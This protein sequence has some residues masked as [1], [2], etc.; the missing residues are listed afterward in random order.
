MKIYDKDERTV[1]LSPSLSKEAVHEQELMGSDLVRLTWYDTRRMTL[2]VGAYVVPFADK[3]DNTHYMLLEPYEPTGEKHKKYKYSPE[4]M[5]PIMMLGKL[6]FIHADGDTSSWGT[7][8]KRLDWTFYGQASTIAAYLC[9]Y[10]NE[11]LRNIAPGINDYIGDSWTAQ[12]VGD[13]PPVASLTFATTDV[14]SAAAEIADKFGCEYHFD[15]EEKVFYLGKISIIHSSQPL[16]P[17]V[18]KSGVNIGVISKSETKEE[19]ANCFQILGGKRNMTQESASGLVQST[20]RLQLDS[21]YYPDSIIDTR[22]PG[23][24]E[25]KIVRQLVFDDV[26]P[27][28]ELYVYNLRERRCWLFQEDSAGN[29]TR[30]EGSATDGVLDPEDGK[31]YKYYAKWYVRL[32]YKTDGEW[33]DY[34]LTEDK[35]IK[36]EAPTIAFQINASDNAVSSALA[37]Q[38]F[39]VV[40]YTEASP[41]KE[42]NSEE[43][44][45]GG[46]QPV[47]GDYRIEF[48]DGDIIIPTTSQQGVCPKADPTSEAQGVPSE[49]N[50]IITL[51]NVV[52]D[53]IYK[54][55]AQEELLETAEREIARLR[56][57]LNVYSFPS[58]P[59]KF[60]ENNPNLY[61]GQRII[62]DDGGD[63]GTAYGAQSYRLDT[64]IR[65]LVTRL[66]HPQMVTITVG[67]E[68]K[69]GTVSTLKDEVQS[70]IS[71]SIGTGDGIGTLTD[72]QWAQLIQNHGGRYFI[73]K[74]KDDTA[75]GEIGFLKGLWIKAKGTFGF[76]SDGNIKA[77][78]GEFSGSVRTDEVRSSNYTG[79]TI[80]DTGYLLTNGATNG[81]GHSKLTIDEIYVRM[82]AVFESLEVKKW[83]VS[84]GDEIQSCAA[85]IISRVDYFTDSGQLLGYSEVRVPWMFNRVPFLLKSFKTSIGRWLYSKSVKMRTTLSPSQLSSVSF[86][87]CYFLADD[88]DTLIENWWDDN[89]LA[90]C[91][92]MNVLRTTRNTFAP[93]KTKDSNVFWWRKVLHVSKNGV[94]ASENPDTLEGN[95]AIIDNKTYHWFDVAFNGSVEYNSSTGEMTGETDGNCFAGSDI[96]AAGDHVVQF[97]NTTQPGRMNL[98][99][100]MVNGGSGHRD[101]DPN[102]DAPCIK[103]FAGIYCFDLN[104]CF[105]GGN[106]CKMTLAPGKKYHFYGS[107]F[108]IITEYGVLPVSQTR[109]EWTEI[110]LEKDE[111]EVTPDYS[112]DILDENTGSFVSRGGYYIDSNGNRHEG[113]AQNPIPKTYVRKCY[114]YDEV[115]HNGGTWLCSIA[116]G[117]HWIADESFTYNNHIYREGTII[118]AGTYSSLDA[119]HQAMCSSHSNYTTDEPSTLSPSWTVLTNG[120]THSETRY[121]R[122]AR[123]K[124]NETL[125]KWEEDDTAGTVPPVLPWEEWLTLAQWEDAQDNPDSEYKAHKMENGD[126]MWTCTRTEF[127]GEQPSLEYQVTR[128][129]IDPDGITVNSYYLGLSDS[130]I[131]INANN[132][133]SYTWYDTFD[134]MVSHVSGG[135]SAMQGWNVWEMTVIHY[136][137]AEGRKPEEQKADVR[138]FSCNRI[139]QDGQIGEE[140]YYLLAE[141][142]VFSTVFPSY[143]YSTMG[144]RW[145]NTSNPAYDDYRL[146]DTTPNINTSMWSTR[147]PA[148]DNSTASSAAKKYLWNFEYRVDGRGTQ[149]A[150]MPRCIGNHAKGIVSIV[151]VYALSVSGQPQSGH[152]IPDDIYSANG[153]SETSISHSDPSKPKTWDDEMYNRSPSESLP[154]QWNMTIT[155]YSDNTKQY[156]YHVSSVRGTRGE[157]GAGTEYVYKLTT[158]DTAPGTPSNPSDR[159][160]DDYVPSG[161][162]DNPTGISFDYQYEWVSERHSTATTG[163]GGFTGGH[164][165]GDFSTPRLVSKWGK[166]GMDGDGVEYVFIT[167]SSNSAPYITDSSSDYGGK[168]YKDDDYLPLSSAGRCTDDPSGTTS[169][170][171][172]EWVIKRTK[173]SPNAETGKREWEEY[174]GTMS[175]WANFSENGESVGTVTKYFRATSTNSAP[176]SAETS[177]SGWTTGTTPSDWSQTKPYLWCQE[178]TV[179]TDG[180]TTRWSNVFLD[181]VWGEKGISGKD[182]WMVTANP[183]NVIIT[184][185]LDTQSSFTTATVSFSAK[186]GNTAATIR[187]ISSP[188]SST[189]K[190]SKSGDSVIVSRPESSGGNYYSEGSFSVTV[191]VTDPDTGSSVSFDIT[192]F[193]Y[194]NL[195]GTWKQSVE[196][197][198]ETI[199]ATKI[200]YTLGASG[201]TVD[202]IKADYESKRN[203][204]GT[205]ETWSTSEDTSGDTKARMNERISTAEGNISRVTEGTGDNLH[206]KQS[207]VTQYSDQITLDVRNGLTNTGID[208]T[209]HNIVAKADNFTIK[210]NSNQTTFSIDSSGN[211]NSSGSAAFNG[212]ITA[213]SGNIGKMSIG[214][215]GALSVSDGTNTTFS[216][217]A[218]GN[219]TIRGA[220]TAT[221]GSFT[222]AVTATSGSFTG[223][224]YAS[225]GTIG[226]LNIYSDGSLLVGTTSDKRFYV[227]TS[228]NVTMK[229]AITATSGTIGKMSVNPSSGVSLLVKNSS[230]QETFK[231]TDG[232]DVHIDGTNISFTATNSFK[233]AVGNSGVVMENDFMSLLI[234]DLTSA[235]PSETNSIRN[236]LGIVVSST[237]GSGANSTITLGTYDSNGNPQTGITFYKDASTS[238]LLLKSDNIS[239]DANDVISNTANTINFSAKNVNFDASKVTFGSS[240]FNDTV[241]GI[242]EDAIGD[243]MSTFTVDANRINFTANDVIGNSGSIS[244]TGHTVTFDANNVTFGDKTV[245]GRIQDKL[246]KFTV[247]AS[248]IVVEGETISI[249]S[250]KTLTFTSAGTI[251]FQAVYVKIDPN[252]LIVNANK[253]N[254]ESKDFTVSS[255]A[256]TMASTSSLDL[257]AATVNIGANQITFGGKTIALGANTLTFTTGVN[258]KIDFSSA[259]VDMKAEQINFKTGN[260][261]INN[262]TENTFSVN[263]SGNV[264]IKGAITATSGSFTGSI[265]ANEGTIGPMTITKSTGSLTFG[266]V[267]ISSAGAFSVANGSNT[268]FSIATDGKVTI[269]KKLEVATDGSLSIKNG[270]DTRFSV[271]TSG[272]VTMKGTITA[273][274]GTIG[275]LSVSSNGTLTIT[276]NRDNVTF[277]AY[278]DGRVSIL[279]DI[280]ATSGYI[281]C[282]EVDGDAL[283]INNG[284]VDTFLVDNNGNVTMN[285]VLLSGAFQTKNGLIQIYNGS[286]YGDWNSESSTIKMTYKQGEED[287][288]KVTND[289]SYTSSVLVYADSEISMFRD[290]VKIT[291]RKENSLEYGF[292]TLKGEGTESLIGSGEIQVYTTSGTLKGCGFSV[293]EF[294]I[295]DPNTNYTELGQTGTFQALNGTVTVMGGIITSI[296]S[297]SGIASDFIPSTDATYKLGDNTSGSQKRW[298]SASINTVNTLKVNVGI[299]SLEVDGIGKAKINAGNASRL[300]LSCTN[301]IYANGTIISSSDVRKKVIRNSVNVSIEDIARTP[302]FDFEWKESKG[303][304][305]LGSSAQY[306][307]TIFPNA[308]EEM[309]DGYLAMDYGSTALAA[310]VLTARTTLTHEE[311]IEKLEN[312]VQ[313][314]NNIINDLKGN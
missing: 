24:N 161:W 223:S 260:F 20:T 18:L 30:I 234:N 28:M 83:S 88:D 257:S 13:L 156:F 10:I 46:I 193:C 192:V 122:K 306:L 202:A 287:F 9:T 267:T 242:A 11:Y 64:H 51:G 284:S 201:S 266:N 297:T 34:I 208:I 40:S 1:I 286:S 300:E 310:A 226:K 289:A 136:D 145:Y 155:T 205:W 291:A 77:N 134:D 296:P 120:V 19:Y 290:L 209:N 69:K 143:S 249:S 126:F 211:L 303:K 93:V 185:N 196:N 76:D 141:S 258:G 197:G 178:K 85:N 177:T 79:D 263:S 180:T 160:V 283:T 227:D 264:T 301:G 179:L 140:E 112:D 114:W 204:V 194:A 139:G 271:D 255:C 98:W 26:Y 87:R 181:G 119:E 5:H 235:S 313:R 237:S 106:P 144:I 78:S 212:K 279:G 66:D 213:S 217:D 113:S 137:L 27:K 261:S 224:V 241:D 173:G 47:Y 129:G 104:K 23:S 299:M 221:S 71:G 162:T 103:G 148:Y 216:V 219:L 108:R 228:G 130:T 111:Y 45:D 166:N 3:G 244:F 230:N 100:K 154:Y 151:E 288:F 33:H 251:D 72:A 68:K 36:D 82:K 210:N 127:S 99:I 37:G 52:V 44:I 256:I 176:T 43:D 90:R 240:S 16:E 150:T 35:Q 164:T 259:T 92:T 233:T 81:L 22:Q 232:G 305:H 70:I 293:H 58:D 175:L 124:W 2:P 247:K 272:N 195:L 56:S 163:T 190:V 75:S 15:F 8:T 252:D 59:I 57:D 278:N 218:N 183:A 268:T 198:E 168:R 187:S 238:K 54:E 285:D 38:E 280:N 73:S 184:Q 132:Y 39:D 65:K 312:E 246:D 67:N 170:T 191:T 207:E 220:V 62:M 309:E 149:Y 138:N 214:S 254:F 95:P 86:C 80:A 42:Y 96:P 199:A 110:A 63:L 167:T 116:D 239:F 304:L 215:N 32:A 4:F 152:H 302:V 274:S 91:Q 281:G 133:N 200:I 25:P 6:P 74:L 48:I 128:W 169:S 222:G 21:A 186:K 292:I 188:T 158:D 121:A 109:G 12:I 50:N 14:L 118:D 308:V 101:Y 142:D 131:V 105:T 53:D 277:K 298:L 49:K 229:G 84:A 41:A 311:K 270:T 250:G 31:Y 231:I 125:Q 295:V 146:S 55:M 282:M 60:K 245:D 97:G 94:P 265:Y 314:L 294:W 115:S 253:I 182:G 189:F 236:K 269:G 273:T 89:D 248:D 147:M 206:I 275:K 172:Y 171:P 262:G 17:Y 29:R 157:D 107:D 159:T 135:I 225:D 102:S 153:N 7:S 117:S 276:D 203:A 165:W 61:I 174:R 307:Q 243:Y 123:M